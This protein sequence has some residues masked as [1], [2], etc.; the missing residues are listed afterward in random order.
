MNAPS[1]LGLS[2]QQND[3]GMTDA[4]RQA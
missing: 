4:D 2:R 1:G 3:G